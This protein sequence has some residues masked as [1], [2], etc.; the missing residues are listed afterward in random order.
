[1][2]ARVEQASQHA[3]HD[4]HVE[5]GGG[6]QDPAG[7]ERLGDLDRVGEPR[8]DR[9]AVEYL[10]VGL[11][12]PDEGDDLV[13]EL[14]IAERLSKL[15]GLLVGADDQHSTKPDALGA[16]TPEP[17][18]NDVALGTDGDQRGAAEQQHIEP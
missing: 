4:R 13:A 14:T 8:E 3:I 6:E 5:R 10:P 12:G 7:I 15:E 17:I 11:V 2:K 16:T 1:M 9:Q 18:A